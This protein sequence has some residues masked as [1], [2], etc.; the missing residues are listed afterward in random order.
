LNHGQELKERSRRKSL[1]I[2]NESGVWAALTRQRALVEEAN[3]R[4][5]HQS[6]E[7]AE[8]RVACA[9][10]KEE[11]A[12]ARAAEATAREDVTRAREE[13]AK[14]C[15]ALVPL[16]ARVKELEED[17][18]LVGGQRD[19]LSAQLGMA[20]AHVRT[21]ENE[22]VTLSGAVRERDEALSGASREL[23]VLRAALRDRDDAL[24][25]SE[26][27]YGELR[28]KVVGWQTHSEGKLLTTL[29]LWCRGPRL[30]LT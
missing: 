27:A 10:V 7:A 8:L 4:L 20:S 17:I 25:A 19:A 12:Q 9:A 21:L 16:L 6:A 26:K 22:V 1:F 15:E 28:D 30:V 5:S 29:W 14:A 11:A 13:A 18:A 3:Q 23:E 24:R 2:R